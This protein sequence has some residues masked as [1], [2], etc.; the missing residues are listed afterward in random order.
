[1]GSSLPA[2]LRAR[3]DHT[4]VAG[5]SMLGL[6][7][8]YRDL[9]GGVF[10]HGEVLPVGAVVVTLQLGDGRIELMAPTPG[11]SFLDGFLAA[12]GGRG[13][14]H[15]VTFEVDD[16]DEAVA[17]LDAHGVPWFGLDRSPEWS[18][19][20]VHP[21]DNGGLLVQLAQIGDLSTV[22]RTDLEGLIA[23]AL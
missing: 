9:L 11:S 13:G 10:S 12:T 5:P 1:M 8:T 4:C 20:F 17:A 19:V 18:E 23:A 6:L 7:A 21:R 16:I 3:V 22:V 15:H 14:V 2:G